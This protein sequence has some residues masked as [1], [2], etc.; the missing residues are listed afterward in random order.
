MSQGGVYK[1]FPNIDS[2]FVAILNE[3]TLGRENRD[4]VDRIVAMDASAVRKLEA[5]FDYL[6]SYVEATVCENGSIWLELMELYAQEPERFSAIRDQLSEVSVLEYVQDQLRTILYE[7][8]TSSGSKP[9]IP[10]E[11]MLSLIHASIHG[12][13]HTFVRQSHLIGTRKPNHVGD[14]RVQF[15]ALFR[16]VAM[17]LSAQQ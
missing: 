16:A 4:E 8:A 1:Y 14:V 11:D 6:C 2:V 10:V 7:A 9:A 3:T 12:I 15:A 13:A 17:L 5:L